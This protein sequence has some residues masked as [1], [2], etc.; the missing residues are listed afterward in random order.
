MNLSEL[1]SGVFVGSL[2]ELSEESIIKRVGELVS[3]SVER[4]LFW[5]INGIGSPDLTVVYV[6]AGCKVENPI[7]LRYISVEGGSQGSNKLPISNPR[8]LV[9]VEKGGEIGI[10]EEFMGKDEKQSYWA[11]S[12]LEVVVGEGGTVRHSYI[13]NQ[14]LNAAHIKWTSVRQVNSRSC[15]SFLLDYCC[16]QM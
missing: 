9:M 8:V 12:V 2:L 1:P 6:P 14:S 15:F 7:C 4:D 16:F 5:S 11:N 13:Q 3:N 10:V